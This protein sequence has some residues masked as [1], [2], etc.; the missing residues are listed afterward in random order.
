MIRL[1]ACHVALATV[2][3]AAAA[4]PALLAAPRPKAQPPPHPH[5]VTVSVGVGVL[6]N[7]CMTWGL[8]VN[9]GTTIAQSAYYTHPKPLVF[10]ACLCRSGLAAVFAACLAGYGAKM[11]IK[12]TNGVYTCRPGDGIL[13]PNATITLTCTACQAGTFSKGGNTTACQPCQ[14][15]QPPPCKVSTGCCAKT[16]TCY[17]RQL[18]AG[19]ACSVAGVTGKCD[20]YGQCKREDGCAWGADGC[21]LKMLPLAHDAWTII[22][23]TA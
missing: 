22:C 11:C 16:G 14:C 17:W 18:S 13:K 10:D 20:A 9:F 3:L 4:A 23:F 21:C 1:D 7:C 6:M 2:R 15:S 12:G 19:T 5:T 8:C